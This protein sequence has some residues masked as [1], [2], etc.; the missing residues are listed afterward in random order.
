MN[1]MYEALLLEVSMTKI[2]PWIRVCADDWAAE[3]AIKASNGVFNFYFT[4]KKSAAVQFKIRVCLE[5]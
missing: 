5:N 1:L 3:S 4:D 2:A